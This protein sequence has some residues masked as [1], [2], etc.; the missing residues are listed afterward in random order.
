MPHYLLPRDCPRVCLRAGE[1]TTEDDRKRF[2][3]GGIERMIAIEFDWYERLRSAR[4]F[5]YELPAAPFQMV[6]RIAGYFISRESVVPAAMREVENSAEEIV[7]RG[8]K[9][10]LLP[11]LWSMR[12]QAV[13]ST[14]E[15]S[16]I[17]MRNA[18]PRS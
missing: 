5:V 13:N 2:F 17:R 15:Y 3:R 12:D 9:L 7:R 11:E 8:Y 1:G 6:D 10:K 14:I 4:L 16:I 18:K